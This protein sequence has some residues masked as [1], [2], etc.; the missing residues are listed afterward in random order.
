MYNTLCYEHE[1]DFNDV[2]TNETRHRDMLLMNKYV[3]TRS[4]VIHVYRATSS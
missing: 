4:N 3:I 2:V 1:D